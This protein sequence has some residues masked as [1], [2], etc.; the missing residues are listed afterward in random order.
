[1]RAVLLWPVVEAFMQPVTN[2]AA[3]PFPLAVP[4]TTEKKTRQHDNAHGQLLDRST[5]PSRDV[6]AIPQRSFTKYS[7]TGA[8][9]KV[10]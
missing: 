3:S 10:L 1:M 5:M 4:E 6:R 9:S 2:V 7:K 8:L